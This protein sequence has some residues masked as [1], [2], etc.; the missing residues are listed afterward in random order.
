MRRGRR[1]FYKGMFVERR[2]SF[3]FGTF[4]GNF[5]GCR[6]K[7]GCRR[8]LKQDEKDGMMKVSKKTG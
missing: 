2:L 4:A 8:G 3:S 7:G 1:R 6:Y 5:R